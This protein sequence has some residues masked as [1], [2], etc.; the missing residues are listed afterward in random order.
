MTMKRIDR[1]QTRLRRLVVDSQA[2]AKQTTK[3][4]LVGVG[5]TYLG[6]GHARAKRLKVVFC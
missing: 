5:T 2:E 6:G 3:V 1:L 4:R